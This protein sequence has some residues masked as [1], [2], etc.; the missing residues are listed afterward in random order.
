MNAQSLTGRVALV[1]GGGTG[2]GRAVALALADAG[3]RIGIHFNT[4]EHAARETL[5]AV[6]TAGGAGILLPGDLTIEDHANA[7]VDQIVAKFGRLDILF[8]NAG[9]PLRH[10]RIE[11]CPTELWRQAFDVNVTSAFF[12]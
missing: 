10:F 6:E 7:V 4:S 8:N 5:A 12:V 11:D 3:A 2:I 9:S 1:T